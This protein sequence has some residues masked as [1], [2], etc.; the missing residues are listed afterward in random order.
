MLRKLNTSPPPT[1]QTPS[2]PSSSSSSTTPTSSILTAARSNLNHVENKN[3]EKPFTLTPAQQQIVDRR[4]ELG[5]SFISTAKNTSLPQPT[6]LPL[7][8]AVQRAQNDSANATPAIMKKIDNL[9]DSKFGNTS[10]DLT[11]SFAITQS[12]MDRDKNDPLIGKTEE[13]K[14]A[15]YNY[16]Q[17][18]GG[19]IDLTTDLITPGSNKPPVVLTR[20]QQQTPSSQT[21]SKSAQ[22]QGVVTIRDNYDPN[23][24][25]SPLQAP[26]SQSIINTNNP[27]QNPTKPDSPPKSNEK[28]YKQI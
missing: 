25:S 15:I 16:A 18:R 6:V 19:L 3:K 17:K 11:G 21:P 22:P 2:S 12:M 20:P 26:I 28:I 14:K 5:T 27:G 13:Q 1:S 23:A 9:S 4:K 8:P 7:P 10:D 24:A